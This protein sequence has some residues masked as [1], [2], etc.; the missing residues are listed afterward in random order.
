MSAERRG[1]VT[2]ATGKPVFIAMAVTLARSFKR[3]HPK[4]DIGFSI[5]TDQPE[6]I[7]ADLADVHIMRLAP[8][9]FGTGFSPKLSLDLFAP[10]PQTLFVDSDCLITRHLGP[11]FDQFAGRPAS[12]VGGYITQGEWFGD[13]DDIRRR[14]ELPHLVKFN[15]GVYYIE[16]GEVSSRIYQSAR[17]LEPAYDELGL[18]RLRGKP[19]EELL[20][21]IALAMHK[22]VPVPD[23]GSILG[24]MFS[25]PGP[26]DVDAVKGRITMRNP[27]PPHPEHRAW[28]PIAEAHP[29]IAHF[30]DA[31]AAR[32][33]YK[34]EERRLELVV[35][36]GWPTGA[37]NAVAALTCSLPMLA[38][39][40]GKAVFRPA[41]RKLFGV[42][43]IAPSSRV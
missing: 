35:G 13:V 22:A 14:F 21:A 28:N 43:A 6:A 3:W 2:L 34:R 19:N 31:H 41:Y 9:Q 11:V 7:P 29:A 37:A 27:P 5:A 17:S 38:A 40:A 39:A 36:R 12:V 23:D 24:D 4:G 8:G 33:P 32:Y 20:M 26:V 30:L 16:R 18:V 42:R 10:A 1:V 15:G 25:Y